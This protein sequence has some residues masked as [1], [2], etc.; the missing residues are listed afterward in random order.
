MPF[1]GIISYLT[2]AVYCTASFVYSLVTE[3]IIGAL[4]GARVSAVD[5]HHLVES[6][7]IMLVYQLSV[8]GLDGVIVHSALPLRRGIMGVMLG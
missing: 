6:V 5:I 1:S 8:L 3:S 7:S 2:A 4:M